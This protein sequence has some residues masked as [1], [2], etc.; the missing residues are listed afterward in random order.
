MLWVM[1]RDAWIFF[2]VLYILLDFCTPVVEGVVSFDTDDCID[3]TRV[4]RPRAERPDCVVQPQPGLVAMTPSEQ[5]LRPAPS[6]ALSGAGTPLPLLIR[7]AS[8]AS[9]DLPDSAEDH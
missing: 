8:A 7:F 4:E 2:L 5:A 1:R 3:F 9:A 6:P